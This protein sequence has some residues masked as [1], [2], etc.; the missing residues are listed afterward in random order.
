MDDGWVNL[1][2]V[3]ESVD[4]LHDDGA[5]LLLAHQLILLQV[6]IQV[7]AFAVLQHSAEAARG[8]SGSD[9]KKKKNVRNT[10]NIEAVY[11]KL[12]YTKG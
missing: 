1:V 4:D 5:T 9:P 12:C 6:E 3:L 7:V 10:L 8:E 2:E 11:F